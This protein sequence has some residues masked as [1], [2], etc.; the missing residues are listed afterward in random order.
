MPLTT[1]AIDAWKCHGEKTKRRMHAS[2]DWKIALNCIELHPWAF[3][4]NAFE[5]R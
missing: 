4:M 3:K 5:T 1:G 2:K